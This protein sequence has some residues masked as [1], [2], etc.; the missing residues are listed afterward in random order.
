MKKLSLLS[1]M[2]LF[3]L[4]TQ[5]KAQGDAPTLQAGLNGI[6]FSKGNLDAELIAQI[7]AEKQRELKTRL[8]KNMLL[9]SLGIDNGL[10][11][12]YIDN[13]ID[14]IATEKDEK[15]RVHNLLENT[16]NLAFVITY[17]EYYL[18]TL[19]PNSPQLRHLRKLAFAY[20][21]DS[22]EIHPKMSLRDISR[23]N[24]T[25]LNKTSTVDIGKD[26]WKT[27]RNQFVG[28]LL[29]IVAEAVKDNAELK[30]LGLLR[31]SYLQ[32]QT[33]S[34]AYYMLAGNTAN[35]FEEFKNKTQV[36][37]EN[38]FEDEYDQIDDILTGSKFNKLYDSV[39][40]VLKRGDYAGLLNY[41]EKITEYDTELSK[42]FGDL[43][44][45]VNQKSE[46]SEVYKAIQNAF[47]FNVNYPTVKYK[48]NALDSVFYDTYGVVPSVIN[49]NSRSVSDTVY[50]TWNTFYNLLEN[51][52]KVELFSQIF[53]KKPSADSIVADVGNQLDLLLKYYGLIK[54]LAAKGTNVD[55]VWKVLQNTYQCGNS[56]SLF[57]LIVGKVDSARKSIT[58]VAGIAQS[59]LEAFTK[60]NGFIAKLRLAE[61]NRYTYLAQYE[62]EI[63]PALLQLS[64]YS[65]EYLQIKDLMF[66]QLLCYATQ[67]KTDLNNLGLNIGNSFIDLL[68]SIDEFDEAATFQ[69]YLNQLAEAGDI[70]SDPKMR[71][72]I[73]KITAFVRSYISV[74]ENADNQFVVNIDAEGFITSLQKL[75]YN[76]FSP[77]GLHF[78]V[79]SNM[80]AFNNPLTLE[81]GTTINNYSFIGEKIG[82]KFKL[83]DWQYINSFSRGETFKYWGKTYIRNAPP[84]EPILSNVHLLLYGSGIMYNLVNT[85]T[86]QD[87][88]SPLVGG[89]FGLTFYNGLDINF[90]VG[91]AIL[92]NTPFLH[93]S[94][95]FF[96]NLG[97]DIQFIE[98]IDRLNQKRKANKTQKKLTEAAKKD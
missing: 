69:K 72:S 87:F 74:S 81:N 31:T 93:P 12:T 80:A 19:K 58:D 17:T 65:Q 11:Y 61:A 13:T 66:Q 23:L 77:W 27:Q 85:G 78:T 37:K 10:F 86:T 91:T 18:Y 14:I 3:L 97:M 44:A 22:T 46:T 59:D 94:V 82:V 84:S 39:L 2:L 67:A 63:E 57:K 64:K 54:T 51:R 73:N 79:G 5:V 32:N 1:V 6:T 89:G 95:P 33:A 15:T 92:D 88:N 8:I 90:S 75:N 28:V 30:A 34:N 70:F 60:V 35:D 41:S 38:D 98:Y 52:Y 53:N 20:G 9:N 48:S 71:S 25:H 68:V 7:I 21:I 16:V 4:S 96:Y 45:L 24:Y 43:L 56:D 47:Y 42:E 76:K 26:Y 40:A 36:K 83:Y 29:D 55:T 62:N 50:K 49:R